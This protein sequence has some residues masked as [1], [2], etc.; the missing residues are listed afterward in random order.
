MVRHLHLLSRHQDN[1]EKWGVWVVL[2]TLL[3]TGQTVSEPHLLPNFFLAY[4]TRTPLHVLRKAFL[5]PLRQS[6]SLLGHFI[7]T[8]LSEQVRP[9]ETPGIIYLSDNYFVQ[10]NLLWSRNDGK[11]KGHSF[12]PNKAS[13]LDANHNC[14]TY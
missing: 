3:A 8:S 4:S 14:T 1:S 10:G 6:V 5:S 9:L 7:H 2:G 12:Y 13:R 11:Q